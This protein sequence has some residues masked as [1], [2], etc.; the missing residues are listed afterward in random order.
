MAGLEEE[1]Q[2]P[3]GV[4]GTQPGWLWELEADLWAGGGFGQDHVALGF[5]LFSHCFLYKLEPS[6]L[7]SP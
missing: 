6:L 2:E 3:G 4:L 5:V 1:S 7:V